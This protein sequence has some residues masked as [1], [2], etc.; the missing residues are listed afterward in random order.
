MKIDAKTLFTYWL[1]LVEILFLT[2]LIAPKPLREKAS[3]LLSC[4]L[5]WSWQGLI[6]MVFL[7]LLGALLLFILSLIIK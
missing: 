6:L 5:S 2:M 7:T 1:I 4:L 3:Y